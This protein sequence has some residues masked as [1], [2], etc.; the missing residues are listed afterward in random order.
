[1]CIKS[2]SYKLIVNSVGGCFAFHSSNFV[3]TIMLDNMIPS[4]IYSG[5]LI[6]LYELYNYSHC[7]YG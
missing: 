4:I 3:T 7:F 5:E 6:Y 1:M 2:F